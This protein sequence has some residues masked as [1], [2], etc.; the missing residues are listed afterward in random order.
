MTIKEKMLVKLEKVL[1]K[2]TSK[3]VCKEI[4]K[5]DNKYIKNGRNMS[6]LRNLIKESIENSNPKIVKIMDEI[7]T[8]YHKIIDQPT[9]FPHK[10]AYELTTLYKGGDFVQWVKVLQFINTHHNV[11]KRDIFNEIFYN[12][13]PR[14]YKNKSDVPDE[15]IKSS[16]NSLYAALHKARL[17][18]YT[19]DHKIY[20]TDLAKQLL[21]ALKLN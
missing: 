9:P 6:N 4:D 10:I 17:I 8:N 11:T 15:I 3:E 12:T 2:K 5:L 20:C 19:S 14:F 21:K 16:H 13:A 18:G 7:Q 1:S